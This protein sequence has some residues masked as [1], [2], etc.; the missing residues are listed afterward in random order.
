MAV[1]KGKVVIENRR[2]DTWDL[3]VYTTRQVQE[4]GEDGEPV[5]RGT[6]DKAVPVMVDMP[7]RRIDF[8]VRLGRSSD[9][10]QVFAQEST[11]EN[12]GGVP[13]ALPSGRAAYNQEEIGAIG[14]VHS[15]V[16][17]LTVEEWQKLLDSQNGAWLQGRLKRGDL[18]VREVAEELVRREI[19]L[20][21]RARL[22]A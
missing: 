2:D 5:F 3:V 21:E 18:I 10:D 16:V 19:E 12:P 1:G 17:E 22:L 15:P 13:K 8:V 11:P 20:P 4:I 14:M 6:G 7:T 9:R